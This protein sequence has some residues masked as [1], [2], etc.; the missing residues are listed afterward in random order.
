MF[1]KLNNLSPE[2]VREFLETSNRSFLIQI[3][4]MFPIRRQLNLEIALR[5]FVNFSKAKGP[6]VGDIVK[7][8][9]GMH[10]RF[11][12]NWGDTFQTSSRNYTGTFYLGE[13]YPVYS[14]GFEPPIRLDL[15]KRKPGHE[16]EIFWFFKNGTRRAHNGIDIQLPVR[17]YEIAE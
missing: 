2:E 16:L 15:L 9:D 3:N 12:K 17:I 7:Y 4:E 8:P 6:R 11:T 14:G 13:D 1:K 10:T 5:R